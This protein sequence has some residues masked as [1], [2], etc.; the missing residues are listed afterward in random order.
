M[1]HHCTCVHS[2][3]NMCGQHC[4]LCCC[5]RRVK[6]QR[7]AANSPASQSCRQRSGADRPTMLLMHV[8]CSQAENVLL[9]SWHWL[10]VADWAP[11]KPTYLPEDNP[12]SGSSSRLLPTSRIA[13]MCSQSCNCNCS[14]TSRATQQCVPCVAQAA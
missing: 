9:T 1:L 7:N 2:Y 4:V 10:F 8:A 3:S 14:S 11:F 12:V 13:C 5:Y 6:Q